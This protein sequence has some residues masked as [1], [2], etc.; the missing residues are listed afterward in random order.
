FSRRTSDESSNS[1]VSAK[2][3]RFGYVLWS[4]EIAGV[5]VRDRARYAQKAVIRPGR[6]G[7]RLRGGE[8][9]GS[10]GIGHSEMGAAELARGKPRVQP[11]PLAL[12]LTM[13]RGE[14]AAPDLGARFAGRDTSEI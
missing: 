12:G 13:S 10:G 8:R 5:D 4:D 9:P 7:Q 14:H 1:L 3:Q 11:V 2:L 6:Q